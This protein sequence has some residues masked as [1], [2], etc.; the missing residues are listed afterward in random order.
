M[1]AKLGLIAILAAL[2]TMFSVGG[3]SKGLK[4]FME[5]NTRWTPYFVIRDMRKTVALK[6]QKD[7]TRRPDAES[8][9][10]QGTEL[11]WGLAG[12]EL[13]LRYA[14]RLTNST[15]ADTGSL[16]RGERK[17]KR[18][19][20]PCHGVSMAGDGPVIAQY[21]PPPDLLGPLV[22]GRKDGYIYSYIRHGGAVMPSY[23][24]AV[25]PAEAW[26][27]VNYIRHMQRTQ[28]R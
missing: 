15:P 2:A 25:A 7:I 3:A 22:R 5:S 1:L 14:D 4:D 26:D 6:P 28:P 21:I 19:C 20:T 13:A 18:V 12:A 9:P 11:T 17:Y 16:G 8:V 24:H 23:G 27:L 10:M